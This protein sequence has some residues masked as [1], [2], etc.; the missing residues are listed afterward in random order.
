MV[1]LI[2]EV[3]KVGSKISPFYSLLKFIKSKK[4]KTI[5]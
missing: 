1:K 5:F 4:K 2:L 3:K